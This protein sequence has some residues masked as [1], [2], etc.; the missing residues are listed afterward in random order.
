MT[1]TFFQ[2]IVVWN[3]V[4]IRF[5]KPVEGA[6]SSSS[7]IK[8]LEKNRQLNHKPLHY[9]SAKVHLYVFKKFMHA[10]TARDVCT[11]LVKPNCG[12]IRQE[13][14]NEKEEKDFE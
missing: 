12:H 9:L 11:I 3:I 1:D 4:Q 7:A 5:T 13:M 14:C 8:K 6:K 10:K 2:T